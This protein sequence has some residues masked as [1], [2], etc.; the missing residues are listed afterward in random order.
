M[1]TRE[2]EQR[3]WGAVVV[4]TMC[5]VLLVGCTKMDE[6]CDYKTP[7]TKKGIIIVNPDKIVK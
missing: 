7:T 1:K 6:E 4:M 5:A 2:R 3:R